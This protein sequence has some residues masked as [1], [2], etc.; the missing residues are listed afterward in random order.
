M[1]PLDRSAAK[2]A[3]AVANIDDKLASIFECAD[4]RLDK[5]Y[6]GVRPRGQRETAA[7]LRGQA[8]GDAI[9]LIDWLSLFIPLRMRVNA[10]S[11]VLRGQPKLSRTN[12]R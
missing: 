2:C 3:L 11:S 8:P 1:P 12:C 9:Q 6:G 5:T 10:V 7:F 4:I